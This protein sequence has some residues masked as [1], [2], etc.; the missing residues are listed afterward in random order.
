MVL[1][2]RFIQIERYRCL[3]LMRAIGEGHVAHG[4]LA[5]TV[6][7]GSL[8]FDAADRL[9]AGEVLRS[10]K[11][12]SRLVGKT[13]ALRRSHRPCARSLVSKK[14]TS[15]AAAKLASAAVKSGPW[16]AL[17]PKG[18]PRAGRRLRL[19]W[20][21]RRLPALNDEVRIASRPAGVSRFPQG[22]PKLQQLQHSILVGTEWTTY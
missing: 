14:V 7:A 10:G 3:S 16:L 4:S 6:R 19:H 15:P 8:G 21:L 18:I 17:S 11:R 9:Q 22:S 13:E 12:G 2:A 20:G 1:V 5:P